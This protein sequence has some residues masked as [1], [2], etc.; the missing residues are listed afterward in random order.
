MG[1]GL[2]KAHENRNNSV[3]YAVFF[4]APVTAP[5]GHATIPGDSGYKVRHNQDRFGG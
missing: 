4:A 5:A 1:Y 2:I 3:N